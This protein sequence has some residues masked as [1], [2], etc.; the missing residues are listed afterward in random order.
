MHKLP[1]PQESNNTSQ[2]KL[3]HQQDT[4]YRRA[5]PCSGARNMVQLQRFPECREKGSFCTT[6]FLSA[7]CAMVNEHS[8]GCKA[9]ASTAS[10]ESFTFSTIFRG[11]FEYIIQH[12]VPCAHNDGSL[13]R[14]NVLP[15]LHQHLQTS[16]LH[17]S[18]QSPECDVSVMW[19]SG[20]DLR[21]EY[22]RATSIV[23]HPQQ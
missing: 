14:F 23:P 18:T 9:K 22:S 2:R 17:S 10:R 12:I 1:Q 8:W 7:Q 19:S 15:P 13:L 20:I 4:A 21:I 6:P 16:A 5:I 11:A 3:T